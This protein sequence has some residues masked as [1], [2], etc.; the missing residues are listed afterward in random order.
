MAKL[1]ELI[2]CLEKHHRGK[3]IIEKGLIWRLGDEKEI[4]IYGNN[5]LPFPNT[6]K[7]LF[8]NN[9]GL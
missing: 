5:W 3:K 1:V 7:V 4:I 9:F 8:S 6:L 2:V